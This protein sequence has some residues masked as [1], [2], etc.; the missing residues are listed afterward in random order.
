MRALS[1]RVLGSLL[2]LLTIVGC[3]INRDLAVSQTRT[4]SSFQSLGPHKLVYRAR[5]AKDCHIAQYQTIFIHEVDIQHIPPKQA[6]LAREAAQEFR[7]VLRHRLETIFPDK[8]VIFASNDPVTP[9][10]L[11]LHCAITELKPGNGFVRWAFAMGWGASV[12]QLEGRG[13]E[14]G[15]AEALFEFARKKSFD[16]YPMGGLNVAVLDN[17]ATL[18]QSM[19]QLAK[20]VA[21]F[22]SSL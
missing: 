3:A 2:A 20:D 19:E 15:R 9:R 16:G 10:T 22:L 13:T 21:S 17:E 5:V 18:K 7:N 4:I 8:R 12:V 1:G 14:E 11:H 6:D